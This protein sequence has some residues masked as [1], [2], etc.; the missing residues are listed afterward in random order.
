MRDR[1]SSLLNPSRPLWGYCLASFPSCCVWENMEAWGK[2]EGWWGGAD[3]GRMVPDKTHGDFI[4]KLTLGLNSALPL[5]GCALLSKELSAPETSPHSTAGRGVSSPT[6]NSPCKGSVQVQNWNKTLRSAQTD[7]ASLPGP[8]EPAGGKPFAR[9]EMV[10][11][12]RKDMEEI[13]FWR[14]E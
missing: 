9:R 8:E 13:L 12:S 6:W 14:T 1:T 5:P 2:G 7:P 10:A 4:I 11:Y 3:L